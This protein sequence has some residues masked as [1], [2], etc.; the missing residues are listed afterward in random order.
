MKIL[1][2]GLDNSAL[3]KNSPL[4][5]R[6]I[7]YGNL[8]EKYTVI[9]PAKQNQAVELSDRVKVFGVAGGSKLFKLIRIYHLAK[10]LIGREK[11]DV[12]TA[13]DPYFLALLGWHLAK[14]FK[15]ALEIQVHG[16]EK[17]CG[18][19]K[20]I[21]R[22][23]LPKADAIRTVSQRLKKQLI[24]EFGVKEEKITVVPIYVEVRSQKSEVRNRINDKF[25]FLTVGRLA[26]VKNLGLQIEALA[27]VTKVHP[28]VELW[29]VGEGPEKENLKFKIKK[30]KLEQNVKL[31]GWQ[32]DLESFYNQADVFLL[33][34]NYEGWGLAVI[35]AASFGLPIVMTDVGCAGEV[36]KDGESGL[37]VPVGDKTALKQAMIQL[38]KEGE[39]IKKIGQAAQQAVLKLPN[40]EQTL[41]LYKAS[42]EKAAEAAFK[43]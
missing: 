34:S 27:E 18:W 28:E 30:L 17:F 15:L 43:L 31:W 10:G 16:W 9:V 29:I 39:L 19:R 25:I 35:E 24:N 32:D 12:I 23:L 1:S 40:K 36:I 22:Y 14:K 33:T 38:I 6:I 26:P 42:W 20:I 8:V 37:V 7:E 21:A 5:A 4:A 13:Q 2:L 11:Y 41:T 3:D